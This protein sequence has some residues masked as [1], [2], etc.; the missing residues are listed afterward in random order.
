MDKPSEQFAPEHGRSRSATRVLGSIGSIT[1]LAGCSIITILFFSGY[2]YT[3]SADL[4]WHYSLIEFIIQHRELPSAGVTRLGPM[5]EYPPGAHVLV[6]AA[7]S[8]L[9]ANVLRALF[10]SCVVAVFIAYLLVITLLGDQSR[11][12][13]FTGAILLVSLIFLLRGTHM[14]F[15]NEIIHEFFYA[16]LVGDLG[17]IFLL[18]VTSRLRQP[19]IAGVFAIVAVYALAWI[20]TASAA[21]LAVAI[22]L[23]QLLALA[24]GYSGERV[25]WLI[26][27]TILLPLT[28]VIHPTFE[29]MVRNA[30]HDGSISISLPL[31]LFGSSLLLLLAPSIWWLHSRS[32]SSIQCEPLVAAGVAIALL[33][34]VQFVFLRLGGLGSPYAVKKHGFMVGTFLVAS[35]AA[36]L[37]STFRRFGLYRRLPASIGFIPVYVTRWIAACVAVV[38]VLPWRGEPLDPIIKYDEEVR[39]IAAAGHPPDLLG[40]TI[41]VNR[42]LPFVVNFAVALAVLELPGWTSAEIDQFAVFGRAEPMP[43]AVQYAVIVST[44]LHPRPECVVENYAPIQIQLVRRDCIEAITVH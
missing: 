1:L 19:A 22:L 28:L 44:L 5:I 42:Q 2:A 39:A 23:A 21:K 17:F 4:A 29:P 11:V 13:C 34:W 15:G 12:E 40:H 38:V 16:Q 6:A 36:W 30:T 31:V 3:T 27:L 37:I 26:A 24:R 35:L 43:S 9:D 14:L 33:A 7:A 8:L 18:I 25:L 41:S 32:G 10:L 20:Y